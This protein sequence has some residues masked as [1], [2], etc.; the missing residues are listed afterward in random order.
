MYEEQKFQE[1][2]TPNI[3]Q[4]KNDGVKRD[5]NSFLKEQTNFQEKIER[6]KNKMILKNEEEQKIL[7]IGKPLINKYSEELVKKISGDAEPVYL[8][9]Y[10]KR[11]DYIKL[12]EEEDKRLLMLKEEEKKRKKKEKELNKNNPYK[13]VRS[14]I[15]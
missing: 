15:K 11:V 14:K 9:L 5:F 7:N 6:N 3:N 2:F 4:R 13:N 12:K 10:N 8:R 1:T